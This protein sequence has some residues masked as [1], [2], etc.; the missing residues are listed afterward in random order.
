MTW[1]GLSRL[2]PG[3]QSWPSNDRGHQDRHDAGS[4]DPP[5]AAPAGG[6]S[7]SVMDRRAFLVTAV[8]AVIAGPR[9]IYAQAAGKVPRIGFLGPSISG[10]DPRVENFRQFREGLR[11]LGYIEGKTITIEWRLA[12]KYE[13][14]PALAA[15][16]VRLNVNVLVTPNTPGALA[17]KRATTTIPIVFTTVGDPVGSGLVASLAR[18]GGNIT[19]LS[20]LATDLSAKRLELLKET[21]RKISRV[22][23]LFNLSNPVHAL[24]V[25]EVQDAADALR[26]QLQP[27]DVQGPGDFERAF[28]EMSR[29][30]TDALMVAQDAFLLNNRIRIA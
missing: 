9:T 22:A 15:E 5:V 17:A 29:E 3:W 27:F 19:G 30:R 2:Q 10:D 25:R 26:M 20:I 23:I 1:T 11:E 18:P 8:A 21:S 6:S 14:Y 4:H 16:L 12:D 13:L 7:H 28:D 24:V